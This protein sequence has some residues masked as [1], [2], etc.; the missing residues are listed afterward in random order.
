MTSMFAERVGA[1][2]REVSLKKAT[3]GLCGPRMAAFELAIVER[4]PLVDLVVK[5]RDGRVGLYLT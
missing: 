1:I 4:V 2:V 3:A 5:V